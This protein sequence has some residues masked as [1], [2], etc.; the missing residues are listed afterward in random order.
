MSFI[1]LTQ[2]TLIGLC[3][4]QLPSALFLILQFATRGF[5]SND[6]QSQVECLL[7]LMATGI[8]S[9]AFLFHV[10]LVFSYAGTQ[11]TPSLAHIGLITVLTWNFIY[12][13]T[14]LLIG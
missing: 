11:L 1:V 4:L 3:Y 10:C 8:T 6:V 2:P 5:G 7:I 12:D 14:T 13:T 9:C